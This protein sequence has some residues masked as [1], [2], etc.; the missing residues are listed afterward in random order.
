[1]TARSAAVQRYVDEAVRFRPDPRRVEQAGWLRVARTLLT[2]EVAAAL[3]DELQ[4]PEES[5]G[6]YR[7]VNVHNPRCPLAFD[8]AEG[9]WHC[10]PAL[11]QHPVWGLNWAGAALLCQALGARLPWSAE[12]ECFAANNEPGR[13]YPWGDAP[14]TP[15]CANYE[16]HHGGTTEVLRF[17]PSE[18]G[19]YDLAGNLGEW[20]QD[21]PA[22]PWR[23][24]ACFE[25]VVK[26]GAWS[27]DAH[28]LRIAARRAK[29]ERLG[30]TTIGLRPVWED[31]T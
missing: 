2:C 30:T 8:R 24:S 11:A 28:Y 15:A 21:R 22:P 9:R 6:A 13:P 5:D 20:C 3:L 10:P 14:P 12:W 25:R 27:K 18:I 17:A 29:W 26:G 4:V 16:E 19:L 1:M 7:F 23:A 31:G